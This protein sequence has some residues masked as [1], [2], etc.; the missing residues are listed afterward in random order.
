MSDGCVFLSGRDSGLLTPVI[1]RVWSSVV[2]FLPRRSNRLRSWTRP[3]HRLGRNMTTEPHTRRMTSVRRPPPP[4]LK[5]SRTYRLFARPSRRLP[6]RP[7]TPQTGVSSVRPGSA[8]Y[9]LVVFVAWRTRQ[10]LMRLG[11]AAEQGAEQRE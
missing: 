4:P 7:P 6:G 10:V 8:T 9:S 5:N 2:Y 1:R 11:T 3:F